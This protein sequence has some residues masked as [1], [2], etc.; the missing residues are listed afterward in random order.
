MEMLGE[1]CSLP[2][3]SKAEPTYGIWINTLQE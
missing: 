2:G 1:A 3:L